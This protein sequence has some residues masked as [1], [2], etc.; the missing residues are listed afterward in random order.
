MEPV[1]DHSP[2]QAVFPIPDE[3]IEIELR[4]IEATKKWDIR[5]SE[6]DKGMDIVSEDSLSNDLSAS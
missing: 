1:C 5:F 6:S 2:A 4:P 3:D